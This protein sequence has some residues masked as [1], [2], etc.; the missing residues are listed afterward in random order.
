MNLIFCFRTILYIDTKATDGEKT[1]GENQSKFG[2]TQ[3]NR[4]GRTKNRK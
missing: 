4:S 3:T 1:T 2:R